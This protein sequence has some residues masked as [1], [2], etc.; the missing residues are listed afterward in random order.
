MITGHDVG[1]EVGEAAILRGDKLDRRPGIRH[2]FKLG[3]NERTNVRRRS[4][5]EPY[6]YGIMYV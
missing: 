3:E 4:I 2:A 5:Q 1:E 6:L